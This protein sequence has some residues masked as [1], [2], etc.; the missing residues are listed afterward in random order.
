MASYGIYVGL[1]LAAVGAVIASFYWMTRTAEAMALDPETLCPESTGPTSETVILFDLTDPL[2]PAQSGQLI[3]RLESVLA[4]EA[5]IG[6][7]LRWVWSAPR[8]QTG[9]PPATLQASEREGR[10]CADAKCCSG[11]STV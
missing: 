1:A 4:A 11:A 2:S 5:D 8:H 6:T 10:K 3:Q 7:S 9:A